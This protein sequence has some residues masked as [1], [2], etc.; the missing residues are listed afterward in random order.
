VIR[1]ALR[2]SNFSADLV[3]RQHLMMGRPRLPASSVFFYD[4]VRM[5][6]RTSGRFFLIDGREPR[7]LFCAAG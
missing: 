7:R 2:R 3:T 6:R 1:A 4:K 5:K